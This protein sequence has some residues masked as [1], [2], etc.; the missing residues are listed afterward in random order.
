MEIVCRMFKLIKYYLLQFYGF[1]IF[2]KRVGVIGFFRVG[3]KR[4][5]SIGDDCGINSGVYILGHWKVL[6]GNNVVL[7]VDAKLLDAGL[8]LNNFANI[9]TPRHTSSFVIIEDDVWIGAGAIILPGVT[10]GRK[11]VV[12]AGSVVT[13]NVAPYTVVAGNPA[14]PIGRTDA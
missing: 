1:Y 13:K 11:S 2:G 4:N 6:I 7:S 3:N 14:R 8:D 12:G 10:V 5:I 9:K